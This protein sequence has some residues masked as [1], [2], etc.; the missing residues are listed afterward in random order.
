MNSFGVMAA[1]FAATAV[2]VPI[3][4]SLSVRWQLFDARGP[5]NIHSRDISR[6]GGAAIALSIAGA[7]W[8]ANSPLALAAWP[9]SVALAIVWITGLADDLHSL[10]PAT[11]LAAQL[12]A[13]II[14]W[15]G[16]WRMPVTGAGL[17][18]IAAVCLF[19]VL[20]INAMNF[21]DGADGLAAGVA[22]A[23][24]VSF[25]ASGISDRHSI[26]LP[27]AW[28]M[29]GASAGFLLFNFPPASILL[30]D[31]GSTVLGFCIAFLG[32]DSFRPSPFP[33]SQP[34]ARLLFPFLAAALP[35]LD[36]L[37]AVVR[38]LRCG[39]SPFH[40]DRRHFYD[41]LLNRGWAP[42]RVALAAYAITTA[43]ALIGWAGM[44][45]G[46][47]PFLVASAALGTLLTAGVALGAVRDGEEPPRI[48][49]AGIR[50][51]NSV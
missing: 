18:S 13:A 30:G 35:L 7:T 38:R 4:K 47:W 6:L 26:A 19:T 15:R 9:L 36:A 1:A 33:G 37:L 40:G 50:T 41:L 20:F 34:G 32:L 25:I 27:L 21:L 23:I 3:V 8:F 44:K 12:S 42:R 17:L 5:L 22:C 48:A 16:G 39:R 31:S 46:V 51:K 14:L 11:R 45:L 43:L 2:L 28:S 29:A 49:I 24:S 10:S